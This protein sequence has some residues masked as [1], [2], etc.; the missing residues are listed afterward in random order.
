M[1]SY[2]GSLDYQIF[3]FDGEGCISCGTINFF[4][5][6]GKTMF[7]LRLCSKEVLNTVIRSLVPPV[8]L[9]VC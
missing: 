5:V 1:G 3:D 8:I 2:V 7:F 6:F 4:E 9:Y